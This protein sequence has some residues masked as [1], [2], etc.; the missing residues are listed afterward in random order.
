MSFTLVISSAA[1][2]PATR[3]ALL[4]ARALLDAGQTLG[5][6]FFYQDGVQIASKLVV[7]PQDETDWAAAW[8]Q[9][10]QEYQLDAVVCI[11]AALRRGL[12]D[13]A[14]A[15]RYGKEAHNLAAGFVL[16]GLGDLHEALQKH[17][18]LVHF[19]GDA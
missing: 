2:D 12:L 7:C 6:V 16:A 15:Q 1:H 19:R 13:S 4:F 8:Q 5:R 10:V 18:R 3:R 11:A 9:L 17:E 14:E